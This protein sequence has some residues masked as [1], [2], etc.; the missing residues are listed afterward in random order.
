MKKALLS[1][2]ALSVMYVV[3]AE[4][5]TPFSATIINNSGQSLYITTGSLP[6]ATHPVRPGNAMV[7]P[8]FASESDMQQPLQ[9]NLDPSLYP[10]LNPS[11]DVEV[12]FYPIAQ[13][14]ST[15]LANQNDLCPPP[16]QLQPPGKAYPPNVENGPILCTNTD[17]AVKYGGIKFSSYTPGIL[18]ITSDGKGGLTCTLNAYTYTSQPIPYRVLNVGQNY[19]PPGGGVSTSGPLPTA[20]DALIDLGTYLGNMNGSVP[21]PL[22]YTVLAGPS[23]QLITA[24]G[25]NSSALL[26]INKGQLFVQHNIGGAISAPNTYASLYAEF[27]G[28][29]GSFCTPYLDANGK[30]VQ[31]KFVLWPTISA[32]MIVGPTSTNTLQT[33]QTF[34]V[35]ISNAIRAKTVTEL[36]NQRMG[37]LVLNAAQGNT[38]A[39]ADSAALH[40][41]IQGTW[42]AHN[43][44]SQLAANLMPDGA[45][46]IVPDIKDYLAISATPADAPNIKIDLSQYFVPPYRTGVVDTI[47]YYLDA[48]YLQPDPQTLQ[49]YGV[50]SFSDSSGLPP[51]V[52]ITGVGQV[53]AVPAGT[54]SQPAGL[55]YTTAGPFSIVNGVLT[56]TGALTPES[57]YQINVRAFDQ[58]TNASAFTTFYLYVSNKQGATTYAAWQKGAEPSFSVLNYQP[59]QKFGTAYLYTSHDFTK[60]YDRNNWEASITTLLNDLGTANTYGA[61]IQ[62]AF[63]D[64]NNLSFQNNEGYWPVA[65]SGDYSAGDVESSIASSGMSTNLTYL[66]STGQIQNLL[67]PLLSY[68]NQDAAGPHIALTV[69]PSNNLKANFTGFNDQQRKIFADMSAIPALDQNSGIVDGISVDLEGGLNSTG[70]TQ[71]YK[72]LADEL[73]Y[74][75]K[76]FS[77]FYFA[78]VESPAF[79][80]ALGPLGALEVSSYDVGTYREP[81]QA[82]ATNLADGSQETIIPGTV[83]LD[84]MGWSQSQIKALYGAYLADS[85]KCDQ[86]TVAGQSYVLTSH[87]WC[88][89]STNQSYSENMRIWSS[90]VQAENLLYADPIQNMA[91]FNGKF[92]LIVPVSWSA[93]QYTNLYLFNP[94]LT[95]DAQG[96]FMKNESQE[97]ACMSGGNINACLFGNVDP[98]LGLPVQAVTPLT[99]QVPNQSTVSYLQI[100]SLPG[101]TKNSGAWSSVKRQ[102]QVDY[103]QTNY[104]VYQDALSAVS[105]T[106]PAVLSHFNQV[107][108]SGLGAY[109]LELFENVP[110]NVTANALGIQGSPTNAAMQSPWYVGFNPDTIPGTTLAP[111]YDKSQ[112]TTIWQAFGALQAGQEQP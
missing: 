97:S 66:D 79:A 53:T 43:S 65:N 14:P 5:S 40:D 92:H 96:L 78:T 20:D 17:P 91:L 89:N 33:S 110:S 35:V 46:P 84:S 62:S 26:Q 23:Q 112:N 93:T 70:D 34:P 13:A 42:L 44:K 108:F 88:N 85:A 109:A 107:N 15:P 30:T 50:S 75:G 90:F 98:T 64:V 24:D 58:K 19:L 87:S 95:S 49:N 81:G 60:S 27:C 82:P 18:S 47:D 51:V 105:A 3:Y 80:E 11:P 28:V 10:V 12:M 29:K 103:I 57:V 37:Q 41:P 31:D 38:P 99:V 101:T 54:A 6:D 48:S 73:A 76:W 56:V 55:G 36:I 8:I 83:P 9:W 61:N 102:G 32:T 1:I 74:Q 71:F 2:V 111:G 16:S 39:I 7:C 104:A 94:D 67:E 106:N 100:S 86:A 21:V 52:D 77:F 63:V 72:L 59:S 22:N 68:L 25:S 4:A 45:N 69:Y